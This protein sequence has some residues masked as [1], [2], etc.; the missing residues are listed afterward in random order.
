MT[1]LPTRG[2]GYVDAHTVAAHTVRGGMGASPVFT[3]ATPCSSIPQGDPYAV[4][5]N[6]CTGHGGNHYTW[7]INGN[8]LNSTSGGD[9]P[10]A[11]DLG[12]SQFMALLTPTNIAIGAAALA[13][14]VIA[15]GKRR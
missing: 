11:L 6:E 14:L 10:N 5:G 12:P 1:Y 8:M 9:P 7:D 15:T 13:V 3:L 4:P 2:M